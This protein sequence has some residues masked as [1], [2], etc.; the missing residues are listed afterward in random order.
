MDGAI[1][2][3]ITIRSIFWAAALAVFFYAPFTLAAV[4]ERFVPHDTSL[5]LYRFEGRSFNETLRHAQ[6]EAREDRH[7]AASLAR[8]YVERARREGEPRFYGYAQALLSPWIARGTATPSMSLT[9]AYIQQHSHHFDAALETL[10]S[11]LA[12]PDPPPE[13]YLLRASIRITRGELLLA[14]Q[15]CR[16]LLGKVRALVVATCAAQAAANAAAIA[17]SRAILTQLLETNVTAD[18]P[19]NLQ[20]HALPEM[21]DERAWALGVL[22]ELAMRAGDPSHAERYYREALSLTPGDAYLR[23]RLADLLLDQRRFH[24]VMALMP[25]NKVD[26]GLLLRWA[27]AERRSNRHCT[28][29]ETLAMRYAQ[30]RRR[31]EQPHERDYA[32]FLL[33]ITGDTHAALEAAQ[34]NWALQKEPSDARVLWEA[35]RARNDATAAAT[36]QIWMEQNDF[37]DAA[38]QSLVRQ[39]TAGG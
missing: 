10:A 27:I 11:V 9:W 4:P 22:A 2:R 16:A 19:G 33:H 35:A 32:R 37:Y 7:L 18:A 24:E 17:R 39:E 20:P 28:P 30:L 6:R 13:A 5:V 1:C 8:E 25:S 36:V 21:D 38:L 23:A 15:D 31:G 14:R 3:R 29:C 34:R 26:D 12:A